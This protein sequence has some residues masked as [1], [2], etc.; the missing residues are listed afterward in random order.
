[1]LQ[2]F[3]INDQF[4]IILFFLPNHLERNVEVLSFMFSPLTLSYTGCIISVRV[5]AA[6]EFTPE[7][8]VLQIWTDYRYECSHVLGYVDTQILPEMSKDI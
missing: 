4:D 8:T 5:T 1:M 2:E 3:A 7:E 6:N